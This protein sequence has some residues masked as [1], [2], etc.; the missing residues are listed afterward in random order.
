VQAELTYSAVGGTV[1]L[2]TDWRPHRT[3]IVADADATAPVQWGDTLVQHH[4]GGRCVVG[5]VPLM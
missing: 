1:K 3:D 5:Y 2:L 4:K